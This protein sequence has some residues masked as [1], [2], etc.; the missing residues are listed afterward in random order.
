[1]CTGQIE[2]IIHV[3]RA[4]REIIHVHRADRGIIHVHRAD[5]DN[6]CVQGRWRR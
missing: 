4:D 2:E 6:P 3:Y 1:M 5:G